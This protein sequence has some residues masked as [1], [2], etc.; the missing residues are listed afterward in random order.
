[1]KEWLYRA[2]RT[3]GQAMLGYLAANLVATVTDVD[4]S[5]R[6]VLINTLLGLFAASVAAGEAAFALATD[7]GGSARQ[8]AS[9]CGLVSMKPT[10]GL[11]SRYGM[12]ELASSLEQ[13]CPVTRTVRENGLVLSA[14]CG[15]DQRDMTT[16]SDGYD[17]AFEG[18]REEVSGLKIG[19]FGGF[20]R[21]C[22]GEVAKCVGRSA[23]RLC[24][25]GAGVEEVQMP[26]PALA[27]DIYV[28]TMAAEA[29]SNLARYDGIRFGNS[30]G[31]V[32]SSRSEGFGEEVRRRIITGS[33]ALSSTY[34]G[35]YY[36]QVSAAKRKLCAM[37][38]EILGTYDV[39]LMPTVGTAAFPL[40]SFDDSPEGLY[41]NDQFTVLANLTGCPAITV[42]CGYDGGLPVGVT[43]MGRKLS[44]MMLY[45]AAAALE[46]ELADVMAVE[47]EGVMG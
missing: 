42:P 46:R 33:Y 17:K 29:S 1:M 15:K 13:I 28:I 20:E 22:D 21:F 12:V 4:L 14:I 8:P 40:G 2:L 31:D 37:I 30:A 23:E 44:E 9:F 34:K 3:F 5:D 16:L 38:D 7:T 27:R 10:Y 18:A 6:S 35:D 41:N 39:I 32:V 25:L 11:V 47:K 24:G 43:L 36:G 19:V 45:G 26:S